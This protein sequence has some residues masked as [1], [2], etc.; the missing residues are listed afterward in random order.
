[1]AR[2]NLMLALLCSLFYFVSAGPLFPRQG[3]AEGTKT[4]DANGQG[5]TCGGDGRYYDTNGQPVQQNGGGQAQNPSTGQPSAG[6]GGPPAG[7]QVG[8]STVR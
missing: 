5:L 2:L 3:C 1:M 4:T 6:A 8:F 7:Y